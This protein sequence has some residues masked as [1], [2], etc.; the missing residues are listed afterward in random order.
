M[1]IKSFITSATIVELGF[2]KGFI[3]LACVSLSSKIVLLRIA[4]KMILNHRTQA[5][6]KDRGHAL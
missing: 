3:S 4:K 5:P 1:L 2:Q 6:I